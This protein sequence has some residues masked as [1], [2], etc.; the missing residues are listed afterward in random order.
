MRRL[1]CKL[2]L[3]SFYQDVVCDSILIWKAADLGQV[4]ALRLPFFLKPDDNIFEIVY[5]LP[6]SLIVTL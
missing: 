1:D 5:F 4:V 2:V 3:M 6:Q